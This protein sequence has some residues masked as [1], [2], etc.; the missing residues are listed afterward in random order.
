MKSSSGARWRAW[1]S[2]ILFWFHLVNAE[3]AI[4]SATR[5]DTLIPTAVAVLSIAPGSFAKSWICIHIL[6]QDNHSTNNKFSK[7]LYFF[8]FIIAIYRGCRTPLV[9][10]DL[11]K[12]VLLKYPVKLSPKILKLSTQFKNHNTWVNTNGASSEYSDK[13]TLTNWWH[14]DS[15]PE[16]P[17]C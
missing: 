13:N 17:A 1:L 15:I 4:T 14:Q 8:L 12:G 11:T 5:M 10:E 3:N 7:S 16:P 2:S 9:I 6:K